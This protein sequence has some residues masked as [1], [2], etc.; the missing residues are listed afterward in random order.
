MT[1]A[2]PTRARASSNGDTCLPPFHGSQ[3][4]G[5]KARRT[6]EEHTAALEVIRQLSGA[7]EAE[8]VAYVDALVASMPVPDELLRTLAFRRST[9]AT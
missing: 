9:S 4:T 1:E 3:M 5:D 2:K 6:P 7:S 8:L